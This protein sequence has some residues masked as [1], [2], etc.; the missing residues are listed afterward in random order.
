MKGLWICLVVFLFLVGACAPVGPNYR[1]P[2]SPLPS[3]FGSLEKGV[4]SEDRPGLVLLSSWWKVLEDPILDALMDRAVRGNLDLRMA[5]ARVQQ[6]RAL[7][8]V[9]EARGLPEG[10]FTGSYDWNRSTES[11]AS[12]RLSSGSGTSAPSLASSNR[13]YN[14]FLLGFDAA[15]EVDI[16][17]GIRREIEAAQSDLAAAEDS[18]RDTL[19]TLQGE[20]ARNYILYRGLQLRLDIAR[21]EVKTRRE[22]VE[23]AEARLQAGLVNELGVSRIRGDLASAEAAIPFLEIS[24]LETLHRLGILLGQ[25]P[26][27]LQTEL[28][29]TAPLPRIPDELPAG[30]PSDLL[31]RRPD[32]RRAERE[33]VAAT[34]RIGVSTAELFPR[35]SLA[36]TF[37]FQNDKLDGLL[38]GGSNFWRIGPNIRWPIVNFKRI[39]ANIEASRAVEEETLARYERSV[40]LS[41]EEVENALVRL[42]REKRR[43]ESL[44]AAVR[45]ND[46]AVQ[47]AM[48]RYVAGVESY[49]AVIDAE[50]ALYTAQDQ[51]A[52]SQQNHVLGFVSLY[53]ALG[54]GWLESDLVASNSE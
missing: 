26:M 46:L 40:L 24:L 43:I 41:L 49:L 15:W 4:T 37:G 39:L 14:F 34:A 32:I 30:L 17:G 3:R 20:V 1:R 29:R 42:A 7:S 35:F 27:N 38:S 21:E 11:G 44:T 8:M 28:S 13:N 50:S 53:K 52:Q 45:S 33:L 10:G 9:S 18:L 23:I 54:G 48:E 51:L 47:L 16:F 6:A 31:R 2:D 22:S 5:E 12:G 36:G 19:V 25:E